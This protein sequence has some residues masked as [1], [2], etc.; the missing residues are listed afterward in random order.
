[1]TV[2]PSFAVDLLCNLGAHVSGWIPR[3]TW[4][5]FFLVNVLPSSEVVA[6]GQFK[7]MAYESLVD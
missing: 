4:S 3:N 5:A 2:A 6:A 7:R 1:L